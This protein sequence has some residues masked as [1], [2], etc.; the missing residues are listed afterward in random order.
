[1]KRFEFRLSI[2][3]EEYLAY[4]RGTAKQVVVRCADGVTVQFPASLLTQFVSTSGIHGDFV[5]TC[6][7]GD[8]GADLRRRT[9]GS[10]N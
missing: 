9:A 10:T 1:M 8:K 2:S 6:D 7:D 4:Y 5:L 3:P